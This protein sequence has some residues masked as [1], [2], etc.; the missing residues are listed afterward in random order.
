MG[1]LVRIQ[2]T[3]FANRIFSGRS[4]ASQVSIVLRQISFL[5]LSDFA[6]LNFDRLASIQRV[7]VVL[8]NETHSVHCVSF[9][10]NLVCI[11]LRRSFEDLF[12][13]SRY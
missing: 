3:H 4:M 8:G 13:V 12:G 2:P 9:S 7:D 5:G 11:V 6:R 1:K 10:Q